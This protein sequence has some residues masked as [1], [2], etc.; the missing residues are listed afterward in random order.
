[1][2]EHFFDTSA[3][4]KHYRAEVGTPQVDALLADPRSRHFLS[5]LA[6]WVRTGQLAVGDFPWFPP[7]S[8]P[9]LPR[10]CGR[11]FTSSK[12]ITTRPGS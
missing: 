1:M 9:M 2:A 7:A 11:S 5:S 10:V 4:I 8:W 3:A 6:R 12:R